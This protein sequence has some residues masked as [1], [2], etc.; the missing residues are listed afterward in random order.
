MRE[1]GWP[2]ER[3]GGEV[4]RQHRPDYQIALYTAILMLL[5]LV[6]MYAIGPQRAN[7]LNMAVGGNYSESYF[8]IKQVVSIILSGVA[9]AALALIPYTIMVKRSSW[10]LIAGLVLCAIL[11]ISGWANLPFAN[12]VN[13]ATSW[14]Q[15]GILGSFQPAEVLKFGLLVYLA[16]FLGARAKEG[17]VNDWH[18]TIL[19]TLIISGVSL[20]I[21]VIIQ[22]D[23]GTGTALLAIIATMLFVAG[24]NR[25]WLAIMAAGVL[26]LG[27]LSIVTM[28]HRM[29]RIMT[30]LQGDNTSIDDAGAYHI[31]HAK[32][33][34]GTG[35]L[36]GVGIGN[37]VQATG[38][39]PEVINDS[40]FA[41]IGE[42]FGFVGLISLVAL[43]VA[44]LMRLLR[45]V[46]RLVD[47]RLKLLAAG[48]FGWF[49]AHVILNIA[50]IIGI[51][52]LTGITLPLVSFGGTSMIFIAAALGLVFQLSRYT[53][54]PSRIREETQHENTRSRRGVGRTRYAS[55]RSA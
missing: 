50:A 45:V 5:G 53:I 41:V 9:F 48:V 54:H 26:T 12:E 3:S 35:G 13:G 23:L 37:S 18:K 51:F 46:D 21:I 25:R 36:F 29:D 31:E 14:F 42:I 55:R 8:F 39:L 33:A 49:G 20:F 28:P 16:V 38:Y 30:F 2:K 27:L 32:I 10:L 40:I 44:L 4:V 6:I 52:P 17:V 47:V 24:V 1:R 11:A 34:I 7:V 15:L 43:F 19:P 22:R